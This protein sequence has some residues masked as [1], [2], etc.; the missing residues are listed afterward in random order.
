MLGRSNKKPTITGYMPVPSIGRIEEYIGRFSP[1]QPTFHR[2]LSD[3]AFNPRSTY[4]TL[5]V[6]A[7]IICFCFK[8]SSNLNLNMNVCL[9]GL[10]KKHNNMWH[11]HAIYCLHRGFE[12]LF[13]TPLSCESSWLSSM[14]PTYAF[15]RTHSDLAFLRATYRTL[16]VTV[17]AT[18]FYF[19]WSIILIQI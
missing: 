10:A 11:A 17:W 12:W 6:K 14:Q 7:R 3:L 19:K 8:W 9:L 15:H 16:S 1:M 18:C 13:S 2:T 5:S 4:L